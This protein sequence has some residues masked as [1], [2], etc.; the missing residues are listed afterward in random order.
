[1]GEA[2]S[3]NERGEP[4]VAGWAYAIVIGGIVLTVLGTM[5]AVDPNRKG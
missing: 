2:G 1:M 5:L 3:D 4:N